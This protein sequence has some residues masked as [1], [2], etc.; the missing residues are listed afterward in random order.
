MSFLST[1]FVAALRN[2]IRRQPLAVAG[3]V[4]LAGFVVCGLCAH[5]AAPDGWGAVS[6][7]G[8]LNRWTIEIVARSDPQEQDDEW[9]THDTGQQKEPYPA[10]FL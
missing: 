8:R 5:W 1:T 7:P 3:V 10:D 6:T 9:Q 4:L 2:R